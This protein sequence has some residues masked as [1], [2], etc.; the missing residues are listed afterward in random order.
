MRGSGKKGLLFLVGERGVPVGVARR[1][2]FPPVAAAR[3]GGVF[4]H[5]QQHEVEGLGGARLAFLARGVG[6]GSWG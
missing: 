3:G 5:Q 1:R 4:L 6:E 2:A